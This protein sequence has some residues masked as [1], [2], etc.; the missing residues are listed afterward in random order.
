[1]KRRQTTVRQA[2]AYLDYRRAL[3]FDM[4]SSEK[5]LL[6]F[7]H[8]QQHGPIPQAN[9]RMGIREI[10]QSSDFVFP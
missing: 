8:A 6:Q 3:G 5:L 7:A 4:Q 1:M 9:R 2:K 10:N